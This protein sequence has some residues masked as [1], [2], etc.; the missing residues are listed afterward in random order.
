MQQELQ[1]QQLQ[2]Q[3]RAFVPHSDLANFQ[4]QLLANQMVG[5]LNN[6]SQFDPSAAMMDQ[7][8]IPDV[9]SGQAYF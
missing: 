7:A 6:Y 9:N 5:D 4:H 1:K 8:L 2:Q 3:A